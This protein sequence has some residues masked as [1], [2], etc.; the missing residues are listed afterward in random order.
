MKRL[1]T[2]LVL[3]GLFGLSACHIEGQGPP[4]PRGP[5]GPEGP[6][7]VPGES[8]YVFEWTGVSFTASNNYEVLLT[9]PSDFVG[10]DSDVALVYFLWPTDNSNE[11]VWRLLPQTVLHP[12]GLLQYNFDFT[13]NDVRLFLDA[14]FNLDYLGAVDTDDWVVRVVV[15]PGDY[16]NNSRV[17]FSDYNAVKQMLGLPELKTPAE[18]AF[19]R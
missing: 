3:L 19:R 7:G 2:I 9:Y 4:G 14:N 17:D 5:Q 16:W 12:D 15:V 18:D 13:K 11:D 10:Y 1:F 6:Q 8:G